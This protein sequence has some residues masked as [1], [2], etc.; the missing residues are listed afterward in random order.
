MW[1]SINT[2]L[3]NRKLPGFLFWLAGAI[4]LAKMCTAQTAGLQPPDTVV[5]GNP[6]SIETSGAGDATFYLLGPGHALKQT[7]HLGQSINLSP[8]DLEIAGQ[9]VAIVCSSTCT[10][11]HL[12]VTAAPVSRLSFLVHPSRVPV[13]PNGSISGV[14]L[15]IDKFHNLVTGPLS[16]NFAVKAGD[17]VLLSRSANSQNGVSWFSTKPG[18]KAGAAQITA[19]VN[20]LVVHRV[21]QLVASDPCNLRI[22]AQRNTKGLIVS[23]EPVR[24]CSGN[25]VPDGTI[26]TFTATTANGKTTV[27]APIKQGTAQA[28]VMVQGSAVISAASGVVMG[29]EIRAGAQ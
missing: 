15:P 9:Y 1:S 21:V 10:S 11:A 18:S 7:V 25:P 26:V 8:N 2:L 3:T 20:D 19:T 14:A 6:A 28:Q 16:V 12:L 24:D 29:N 23:T 5:A 22:T 4:L 17:S 13:G 27:D